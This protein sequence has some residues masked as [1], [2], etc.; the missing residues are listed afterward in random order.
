MHLHGDSKHIC[1]AIKFGQIYGPHIV[2]P[3]VKGNLKSHTRV[4][5][6][7]AAPT[8][9][10][11]AQVLLSGARSLQRFTE[12]IQ[13]LANHMVF[14]F[15]DWDAVDSA[16]PK[17]NVVCSSFSTYHLSDLLLCTGTKTFDNTVR[18]KV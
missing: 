14:G 4:K 17:K 12:A 7:A 15:V 16:P 9:E 8:T 13:F 3:S 6:D 11:T 1:R 10:S 2:P 18:D 5:V